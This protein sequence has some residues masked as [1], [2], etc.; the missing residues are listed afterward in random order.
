MICLE[1]EKAK[2]LEN[3]NNLKNHN[4]NYFKDKM[5]MV[6][7]SILNTPQNNDEVSVNDSDEEEKV[8]TKMEL[9]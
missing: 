5:N 7:T 4:K 8:E 2:N 3:L 9:V 6:K 1:K